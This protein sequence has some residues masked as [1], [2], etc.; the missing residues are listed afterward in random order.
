MLL[1][2]F[3]MIFIVILFDLIINNVISRLRYFSQMFV[4]TLFPTCSY[5]Y[6]VIPPYAEKSCWVSSHLSTLF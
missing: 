6:F 4:L 3:G 5:R 2:R 1:N